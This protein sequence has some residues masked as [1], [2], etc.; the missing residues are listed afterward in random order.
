VL[1]TVSP[2]QHKAKHSCEVHGNTCRSFAVHVLQ[3]DLHFSVSCSRN[4]KIQGHLQ[5]LHRKK[6]LHA[7]KHL[8]PTLI[9]AASVPCT[10]CDVPR[11]TGWEGGG[12]PHDVRLELNGPSVDKCSGERRRWNRGMRL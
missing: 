5:N 8:Q 7:I 4:K 12:P 2:Y 1:L 6:H 3:L 10:G 11:D 9:F